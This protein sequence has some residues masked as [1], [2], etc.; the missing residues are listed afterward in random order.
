M[1]KERE[2]VTVETRRRLDEI[3]FWASKSGRTHFYHQ[4]EPRL[5]AGDGTARRRAWRQQ[6]GKHSP[7]WTWLRSPLLHF[8]LVMFIIS[9]TVAIALAASDLPDFAGFAACSMTAFA[10]LR[11]Y[12]HLR[13]SSGST[14][15]KVQLITILVFFGLGSLLFLA[16][17]GLRIIAILSA[18]LS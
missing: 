8:V 3:L 14:K 7:R 11:A 18:M 17:I 15:S 5:L 12:R 6:S 2:D 9:P 16:L 13:R 4:L 1:L 10:A